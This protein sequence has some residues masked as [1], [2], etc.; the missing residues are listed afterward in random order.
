MLYGEC[1]PAHRSGLS[2]NG[3]CPNFRCSATAT[4]ALRLGLGSTRI[5]ERPFLMAY[6][7]HRLLNNDHKAVDRFTEIHWVPM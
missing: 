3:A 5:P 6:R 2:N 4:S 1:L 7:R